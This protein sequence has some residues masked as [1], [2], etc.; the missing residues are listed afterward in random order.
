MPACRRFGRNRSGRASFTAGGMPRYFQFCTRCAPPSFCQPRREA[1]LTGP[2]SLVTSA[3]SGCSVSSI[4]ELNTTFIRE[5]NTPLNNTLFTN[6]TM[7]PMHESA[8]R[9]YEAALLLAKTEGQSAVARL[10]NESPQTVKNWESRGVSKDGAMKAQAA[11]GCDANWIRSGTGQMMLQAVPSPLPMFGAEPWHEFQPVR[12]GKIH[13]VPV[14]GQGS[15]GN[16][17]ERMW[18][19]GDFPVGVTNEYAEVASTD[20]HAFI[21]RVVGTSMVPKYSPGD[22]ALVEPGTEPDLEDEVLVRLTDGQTILK[23][24]LSRRGGHYRLGSFNDPAVLMYEFADVSWI[25][26]VAYPVP[27]RKIKTRV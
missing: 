21:I 27:A 17:P 16:L 9:L 8:A 20:P 2:P 26:Y 6:G 1:T 5:S 15:G 12:P 19:D 23:R 24:L 3:Q 11:W 10:L 25:Y 14:V 22:F 18:T 7:A 13:G 4:P